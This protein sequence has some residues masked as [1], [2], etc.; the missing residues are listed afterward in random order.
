ME[1]RKPITV[2]STVQAPLDKVWEFWTKPEHIINWAFASSDWEVPYAENNVQV[3]G[4]FKTTMAAKDKSSSFDFIG[5]YVNVKDQEL[6][7]YDIQDGRHVVV[8][9]FQT[10]EGIKITETFDPY[11]EY[12]DEIERS[13]WE[14]ILASFKKYAENSK[15]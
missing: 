5:T 11:P 4:K 3:G 12:S 6:L 15:V 7:E 14:A 8:E 10:P 2:E 1:K 9:F 13:G